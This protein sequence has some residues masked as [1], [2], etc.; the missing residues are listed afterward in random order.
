MTS[1]IS[2]V[3]STPLLPDDADLSLVGRTETC[4]LLTARVLVI[5]QRLI[6]RY[7]MEGHPIR[8]IRDAI[9]AAEADAWL[10][11]FPH[12]FLPDLADEVVRHLLAKT[13]AHPEYAQAA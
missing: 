7:R 6:E 3:K 2:S 8:L 10:S 1:Q 4:R 5:K 11:G 9:A 12:L 13:A